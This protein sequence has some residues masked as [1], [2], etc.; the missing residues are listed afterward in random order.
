MRKRILVMALSLCFAIT[1]T[2]GSAERYVREREMLTVAGQQEVWQLVW[3]GAP[4][5][6]CGAEELDA[7]ITCPCNGFAYG[8]KGKLILSRVRGDHEIESLNLGPLFDGQEHPSAQP[9]SDGLSYL[10]RWP[11]LAEDSD[12]LSHPKNGFVSEVHR[13]APMHVMELRDYDHDGNATEF[14]VQVATLPCGKR[15]YV[16]VGVSK[17]NRHLHALASTANPKTPL[18]LPLQ[19]WQA[20]LENGKHHVVA[21]WRCGDHGSEEFEDSVVSAEAGAIRVIDRT[22]TCMENGERGKLLKQTSR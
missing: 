9:A 7:S 16:A 15:Q 14:L 1:A 2:V 13:R 17:R 4:S 8:E 22:F 3:D 10:Q 5:S 19:V 20:L 18:V 21:T 11:M 12:Q 6:A